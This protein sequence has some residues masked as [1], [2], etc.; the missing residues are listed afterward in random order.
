MFIAHEGMFSNLRAENPNER[1]RMQ[2][3]VA[4]DGGFWK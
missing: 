4:P 3:D 1:H 2:A